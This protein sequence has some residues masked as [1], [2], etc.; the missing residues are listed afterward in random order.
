VKHRYTKRHKNLMAVLRDAR[1]AAGLSQRDVCKKLKRGKT[2]VSVVE[3]GERDLSILEFPDYAKA[4]G[5][6]PVEL[7]QRFLGIGQEL[8]PPPG[9]RQGT[10]RPK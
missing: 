2:F 8:A 7:F 4:V 3:L 10:A 1:E 5:V 6:D 9:K